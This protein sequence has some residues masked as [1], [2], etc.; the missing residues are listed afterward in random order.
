VAAREVIPDNA[1]CAIVRACTYYPEVPGSYLLNSLQA[2][3][4]TGAYDRKLRK[5]ASVPVSIVGEF[6][7]SR[8]A[9]RK[10]KAST[11]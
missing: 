2:A 3:R 10:M 9:R 7:L 5:L 4:A 11:I 8:Y 6:A 1:K